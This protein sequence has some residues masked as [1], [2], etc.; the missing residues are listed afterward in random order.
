MT[1]L[2]KAILYWQEDV[3]HVCLYLARD[4]R[5]LH[6]ERYEE[7]CDRDKCPIPR[8]FEK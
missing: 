1:N 3:T 2:R 7:E 4:G 5:C 6:P 8:R